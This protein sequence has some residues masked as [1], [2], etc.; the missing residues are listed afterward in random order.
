MEEGGILVVDDDRNILCLVRERFRKEGIRVQCAENGDEALLKIQE[1]SIVLMLTDLNM[2]G[3]NGLELA[4]RARELAPDLRIV[5]CTAS[6]SPEISELASSAG[7]AKVL[8]KPF[9]FPEI[10]AL[11]RQ[12]GEMGRVVNAPPTSS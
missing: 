9:I 10:L 2:P 11:A 5:M 3:M 4:R 8:G 12:Y 7:I 1:S 6:I